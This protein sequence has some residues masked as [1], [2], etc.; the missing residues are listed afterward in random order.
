MMHPDDMEIPY[1][2]RLDLDDWIN[3]EVDTGPDV[4][5]DTLSSPQARAAF[6]RLGGYELALM[7]ALIRCLCQEMIDD[8]DEAYLTGAVADP[9]C[10]AHHIGA[11]NGRVANFDDL[12][13]VVLSESWDLPPA[14]VPMVHVMLPYTFD[15]WSAWS[16]FL[17]VQWRTLYW[18]CSIEEAWAQLPEPARRALERSTEHSVWFGE[19]SEQWATAGP[20]DLFIA[21]REA[22]FEEN[23]ERRRVRIFPTIG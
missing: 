9:T 12:D 1:L 3:P 13:I 22:F 15:R 6:R 5:A 20:V 7:P 8:V 2:P 10:K 19:G 16:Q 11:D 17:E 14:E 23:D 18:D 21:D 4:L